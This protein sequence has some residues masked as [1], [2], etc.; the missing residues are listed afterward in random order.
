MSGVQVQALSLITAFILITNIWIDFLFE[1][2][3]LKR[4]NGPILSKAQAA[5]PGKINKI[6]RPERPALSLSVSQK[7]PAFQAL[8]IV[9]D[10]FP[11]LA[12]WALESIGPLGL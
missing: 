6:V 3:P 8:Q 1:L 9:W 11:G 5:R 2:K 12:A 7:V 10:G 4:P